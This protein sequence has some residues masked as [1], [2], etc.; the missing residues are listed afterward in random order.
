MRERFIGES[1]EP[2]PGEFDPQG[3]GAG[4]PG[5]P[6]RFRWRGEI[7]EV[8]EVLSSGRELRPDTG[9]STERYARRRWFHLRTAGGLEMKIY[10]DR[11]PRTAGERKKPWRLYSLLEP[12]GD[13]SGA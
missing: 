8:A 2:L 12:D 11:Y 6:L 9:G 3:M 10:C 7:H 1:I 5:L 13:E 4:L